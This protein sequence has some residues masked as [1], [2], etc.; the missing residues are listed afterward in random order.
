MERIKHFELELSDHQALSSGDY[1]WQD[2]NQASPRNGVGNPDDMDTFLPCHYF[3]YFA[4][5]STGGYI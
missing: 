4:G 5:T 1:P 3:D 2:S